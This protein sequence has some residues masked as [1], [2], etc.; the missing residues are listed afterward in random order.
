M[1]EHRDPVRPRALLVLQIAALVLLGGLHVASRALGPP[2]L[3]RAFDLD[4]EANVPTVWSSIGLTIAAAQ[5]LRAR[6][7]ATDAPARRFL[8]IAAATF[9]VLA[10]DESAAGHEALAAWLLART[11]AAGAP[12]VVVWAAGGVALLPVALLLLRGALASPAPARRWLV[13]G[14]CVY[15]AC[16]LGVEAAS[17]AWAR[18][19]GW[20]GPYQAMVVIEECGEMLGAALCARGFGALLGGISPPGDRSGAGSGRAASTRGRRGRSPR[21]RRRPP[22]PV[23]TTRR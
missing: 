5:A 19:H 15:V 22:P 7:A 9:A 18:R 1:R 6:A 14:G 20:S 23:P 13:A 16:A 8:A 3:A 4:A 17:H 11:S 10:V 12:P 2:W 21:R